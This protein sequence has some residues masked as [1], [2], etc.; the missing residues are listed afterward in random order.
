MRRVS[1]VTLDWSEIIGGHKTA[2]NDD[3]RD[4]RYEPRKTKYMN[5][6]N[7]SPIFHYSV[8]GVITAHNFTSM[9][10]DDRNVARVSVQHPFSGKT[11]RR[12]D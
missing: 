11:H 3:T 9:K 1:T 2:H 7:L 8:W 5:H 12:H 6:F 10:R 4:E